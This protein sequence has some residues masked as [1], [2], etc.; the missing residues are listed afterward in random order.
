MW[1]HNKKEESL[2][3]K[4]QKKNREMS[5]DDIS[6]SQAKY[7]TFYNFFS[8]ESSTYLFLSWPI[9]LSFYSAFIRGKNFRSEA[10]YVRRCVAQHAS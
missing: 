2:K 10:I 3:H 4:V 7:H 8:T 9:S 1:F 6:L 5:K